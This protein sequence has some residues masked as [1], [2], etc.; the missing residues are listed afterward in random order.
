MRNT[1]DWRE[2]QKFIQKL[3]EYRGNLT[4]VS[5]VI[6]CDIELGLYV[7]SQLVPEA[8]TRSGYY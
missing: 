2:R 3:K 7:L 8:P 1:S 4:T 6:F 5:P